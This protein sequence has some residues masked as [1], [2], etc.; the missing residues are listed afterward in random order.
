MHAHPSVQYA[1]RLFA[2]IDSFFQKG[3]YH[4]VF[5]MLRMKKS[6]HMAVFA[7]VETGKM[8]GLFRIH[9]HTSASSSKVFQGPLKEVLD[10][11]SIS[12]GL[13]SLA[14]H[15]REGSLAAR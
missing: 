14:F 2:T 13:R 10:P 8:N 9:L 5:L 1:I 15:R 4:L 7:Q 6:A 11:N 3:D 12:Q